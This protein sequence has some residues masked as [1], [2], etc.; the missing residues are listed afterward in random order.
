MGTHSSYELSC[1]SRTV[2][3]SIVVILT[4]TFRASCYSTRLS[5][6]HTPV[7]IWAVCLEQ[8]TVPSL[9]LGILTCTFGASCYSTRLA[10]AP[11]FYDWGGGGGN[12][13]F[14]TPPPLRLTPHFYFP[15]ELYVYIT[16]T[17]NYLAFFI[18][19]LII[20]WTISIN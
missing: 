19:Q 10:C 1:I 11:H 8:Y 14:V 2:H 7:I 12:G 20:L 3:S 18:Y 13:M 15:L 16:L 17:N 4:C 9:L 5:W 6:A